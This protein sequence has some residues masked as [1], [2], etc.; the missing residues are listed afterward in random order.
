M[1]CHGPNHAMVQANPWPKP[2]HDPQ[3]MPWP[4]PYH[5]PNHGLA[6]QVNA[7]PSLSATTGSDLVLKTGVINDVLNVVFPDDFP[8]A[9]SLYLSA[10]SPP[11]R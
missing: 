11:R 5:D 7:S 4:K 8:E 6:R 2:C 9:L 3:A 10:R 1:A